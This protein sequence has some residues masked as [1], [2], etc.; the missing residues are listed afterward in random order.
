MSAIAEEAQTDEIEVAKVGGE[1]F[2]IPDDLYIPPDALQLI[3]ES[4]EG[5]L[6]LL[7]YL[8]RKQKIE[9]LE[10]NV[11]DITKQYLE[12]MGMMQELRVDLAA[13]YMLMAATLIEIKSRMLLPRPEAED[14]ELL[15]E[16]PRSALIARLQVYEQ[17]KLAAEQLN[18]LPRVER[19]FYTTHSKVVLPPASVVQP[20]AEL[21]DVLSA[22]TNMFRSQHRK[23][24]HLV[25]FEELSVRERMSIVLEKIVPY[26][27]RNFNQFYDPQEGKQGIVVSLLAVLELQRQRALLIKQ[28]E[29]FSDIY[30]QSMSSDEQV[31]HISEEEN[32]D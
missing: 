19:D 7:L 11:C 15:E 5:P 8:I 10:L 2:A 29:E 28:I 31:A 24:E 23:S 27:F 12:Y 6:D 1:S 32:E 22:L 3:L 21:D 9:I 14:E 30:V 25:K 17:F 18:E 13:E 26:E 20:R 4:F 16:D